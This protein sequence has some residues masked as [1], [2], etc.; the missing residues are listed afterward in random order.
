MKNAASPYLQETE[1]FDQ[2]AGKN[3]P[4]GKR[5]LAFSLAYQKE[6]GTFTDQEITALQD[7]VG[8]ALKSEYRVEF[9]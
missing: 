2:Y 6:T 7:R 1:L 8:Q 5:S 9:R 3:I 4:K